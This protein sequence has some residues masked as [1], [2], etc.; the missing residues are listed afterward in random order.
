[1][2][3]LAHQ[4][5]KYA[6]DGALVKFI[7][8]RFGNVLG[9]NGSVIPRFKTTDRERRAGYCNASSGYTLFYDYSGSVPIGI[10]SGKYG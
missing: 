2:F 1:M 7:T 5:S 3:S 10:G 9:S 8:T 4:L 6:N